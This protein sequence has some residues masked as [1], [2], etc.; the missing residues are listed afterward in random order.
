MDSEGTKY[1]DKKVIVI[2]KIS[3][4]INKIQWIY[5]FL[6]NNLKR[7]ILTTLKIIVQFK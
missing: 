4:K 1:D 7:K 2:K 6:I 3:G 5:K